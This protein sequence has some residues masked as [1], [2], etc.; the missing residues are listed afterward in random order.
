M[1]AVVVELKNDFAA[2]LSDDGCIKS[3]KNQNYKIGQVIKLNPSGIHISKELRILAASAAIIFIALGSG[4]WAYATPYTYV[5]LDVNPS[6]EFTINRFDR[7]ID[8]N[9]V[10]DDGAEIVDEISL[11]NLENSTI[12]DAVVTSIDQISELDYFDGNT[13]GGIVIATSSED[14]EKAE[15]LAQILQQTVEQESIKNGDDVVVEAFSVGLDRVEQAR[16]LGVTPGKLNLVEK[17]QEASSDP[18]SINIEEWLNKPVKDIMKATKDYKNESVDTVA[19]SEKDELV[20]ITDQPENPDEEQTTIDKEQPNID[21]N[22]DQKAEEA[23]ANQLGK[24]VKEKDEDSDANQPDKEVK[25]KNE[26]AE[27]AVGNGKENGKSNPSSKNNGNE[28]KNPKDPAKKP[29]KDSNDSKDLIAPVDNDDDLADSSDIETENNGIAKGKDQSDSNETNNAGG[30]S[31]QDTDNGPDNS[32]EIAENESGNK[33]GNSKDTEN[34]TN[35]ETNTEESNNVNEGSDSSSLN[36]NSGKEGNSTNESN[37]S[38]KSEHN[39]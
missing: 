29:S 9:A 13:E 18:D 32:S 10:N 31:E 20:T 22:K 38:G 19:T 3:I 30:K 7:V 6:I 17:L 37:N 8:V 26:D 33:G 14:M 23:G 2:V 15:E 5:S 21:E 28:A 39:K 11:D 24:E 4:A 34:G 1:K 12:Q 35:A 27:K 36:S 25:G 16:E